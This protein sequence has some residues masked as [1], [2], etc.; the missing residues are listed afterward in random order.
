MIEKKRYVVCRLPQTLILILFWIL[1]SCGVVLAQE[2]ADIG[3]I[4]LPNSSNISSQYIYDSESE[5]Y[6]F[7]QEIGGY[8]IGIP[9]VLTIKEFEANMIPIHELDF[10]KCIKSV[11]FSI[12]LDEIES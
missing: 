12:N 1:S 9:R 6:I 2:E 3:G 7:S 4:S 8:P 10:H 11:N 5:R